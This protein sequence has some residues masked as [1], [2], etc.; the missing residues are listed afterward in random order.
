MGFGFII[1][2]F[3][4]WKSTNFFG[5]PSI[6]DCNYFFFFFCKYNCNYTF[7]KQSIF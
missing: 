5:I 1:D 2:F 6:L 7:V 4:S 3:N